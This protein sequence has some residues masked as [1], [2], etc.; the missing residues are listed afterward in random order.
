AKWDNFDELINLEKLNQ[1]EWAPDPKS[2]A[3]FV[4][5]AFNCTPFFYVDE[6]NH[7]IGGLEYQIINKIFYKWPHVYKLVNI[8][9]YKY[10]YEQW[11]IIL[12]RVVN[13]SSDL[14][15]CSQWQV[16]M[17]SSLV[18]TTYPLKQICVTF[19]VPKPKLLPR[20]TFILQPFS[21]ILWFMT[22]VMFFLVSITI[23]ETQRVYRMFQEYYAKDTTIVF[24]QLI[25]LW[26]LGGSSGMPRST[27][28]TLR[29]VYLIW[30]IF[31]VM[32][33]TY[34]SAGITSALTNPQFTN[35]IKTVEDMVNHNIKWLEDTFLKTSFQ[36]SDVENYRK[37]GDLGTSEK[38]R[39]VAIIVKQLSTLYLTDTEDLDDYERTNLTVLKECIGNFYLVFAMKKRS[40]YTRIIDKYFG[41]FQEQGLVQFWLKNATYFDSSRGHFKSLYSL[42]SDDVDQHNIDLKRRR[43]CY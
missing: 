34:Y 29:L 36:T 43:Y 23:I 6:E 16:M 41:R 37:L 9:E 3:P 14:A 4:V 28:H 19:L 24:F 25:R 10:K 42:Y 22:I 17:N 11:A 7:I 15:A 30:F 32:Y 31:C 33:S 35:V 21:V 27:H 38:R 12:R 1:P 40:P 5:S 18:D 13:K 26:T 8:T 2:G 39:N 20:F